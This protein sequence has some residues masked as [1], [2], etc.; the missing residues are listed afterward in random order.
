MNMFEFDEPKVDGEG[1]A[2]NVAT[3]DDL[4]TDE[5]PLVTDPYHVGT[6]GEPH[7]ADQ[8]QEDWM[9]LNEDPLK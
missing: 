3:L 7:P 6:A 4:E 8:I 5:P 1:D 9:S 2:N